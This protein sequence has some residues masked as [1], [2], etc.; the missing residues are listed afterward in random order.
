MSQGIPKIYDQP[1]VGRS[2]IIGNVMDASDLI[3]E[4][5]LRQAV[6]ELYSAVFGGRKDGKRMLGIQ[7]YIDETKEGTRQ[8]KLASEQA[9]KSATSAA[10][11][12]AGNRRLLVI[13]ICVGV[14]APVLV[15]C[16]RL[17]AAAHGIHL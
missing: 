1:S 3:D 10:E 6:A 9:F 11:K 4:Q 17:V 16:I 7:D 5:K 8:S 13:S 15:E 14:G 2:D 12:T